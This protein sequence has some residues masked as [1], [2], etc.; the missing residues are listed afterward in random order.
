MPYQQRSCRPTRLW[1]SPTSGLLCRGLHW[2]LSDRLI[3]S[4]LDVPSL[5]G[6]TSVAFK[7]LGGMVPRLGVGRG[8]EN[9]GVS[10]SLP[11]VA[12]AAALSVAKSS[13]RRRGARPQSRSV[14][15]NPSGALPAGPGSWS[16]IWVAAHLPTPSP[17]CL[18]GREVVAAAA[19][20]AAAVAAAVAAADRGR[21]RVTPD[22]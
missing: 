16:V 1:T 5:D 13:L 19:A 15:L 2:T 12:A 18:W 17:L 20:A 8:P 11:V 10:L 14:R 7:V 22:D 21:F 6:T 3:A 9:Q 4:P